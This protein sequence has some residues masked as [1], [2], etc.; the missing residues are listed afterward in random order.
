MLRL[1]SAVEALHEPEVALDGQAPG[2]EGS[3]GIELA[4]DQRVE[5]VGAARE[6]TI[7]VGSVFREDVDPTTIVGFVGTSI[8][9]EQ[10]LTNIIP[11]YLE[12][13][14]CVISTETDAYTYTIQGG[15]PQL[16]GRGDLHDPNFSS[17]A[18][19]TLL[20]FE[21]GASI[22]ATYSLTVYPSDLMLNEFK[23]L[24]SVRLF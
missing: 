8:H 11:D 7:G 18:R 17:Y 4:V 1:E 3:A 23:S 24:T 6:P 21:T 12:G 14:M 22:S 19:S 15:L 16:V 5:V 13:L 10:V 2:L 9:W 20:D